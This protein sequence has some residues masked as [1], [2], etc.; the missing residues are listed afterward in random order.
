MRH[1]L[2]VSIA[3]TACADDPQSTTT[4]D[5]GANQRLERETIIRDGSAQRGLRNGL[6]IAGLAEAEV[7]LAHCWSEATWACPGP[8]SDACGGGAVVAG[9]AD[10]PCAQQR[11]G[12]GMFQFDAGTHADTLG[13]Y[14]PAILSVEGSVNAA[15]DYV[16]NMTINSVYTPATVVD[17]ASAIAWLDAVAVDGPT[18]DAWLKTVVHYYNGCNPA[19]CSVYAQRRAKY[20]EALRTVLAERGAEWWSAT[21]T[22]NTWVTP[23]AHTWMIDFNIVNPWVPGNSSCFGTPLNQ[24]V[25]AGEDWANA[26]G[27]PVRAIGAGT[28][29]YAANANYP[30]SVV[31]I[32]HDLNTAERAALGIAGSSIYSQYGHLANVSVAVGTPVAAGQ[33]IATVLNQAGNSH[34]H[35]EVRTVERP[36]LCAFSVPGPGYTGPGTDARSWGYLDPA[37]SVAALASASGPTTCDNDVPL[38]GTA[39][40]NQGE[41]IEYVCAR[42]GLPSNQQ[43][44]ARPCTGGATCSGNACQATSSCS[45]HTTI[46]TCDATGGA[47][48]WYACANECHPTG[49]PI[50]QACPP[51]CSAMTTV[52]T[53]DATGGACA[54]YAC[55][56]ECHPT[57]TDIDDVCGGG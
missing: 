34:L 53:C 47:C 32:R 57:G 28:V 55:A 37:S 8:A 36:Q 9:S 45:Q 29:V 7:H 20:D 54:W 39:C 15:I 19:T 4:S 33:Q 40:A 44:D 24:L 38:G 23:L 17:R 46:P 25:H 1:V 18:Y 21:T 31:V 51:V 22:S 30:G 56:N 16:V 52:E 48:A 11:G 49:T 43:W 5:L 14:G 42:P 26:A 10:G 35:W 6:L 27:T 41:P 13:T 12:L 2:L 50:E 3:F